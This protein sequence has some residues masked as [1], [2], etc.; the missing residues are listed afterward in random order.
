MIQLSLSS[1]EG[2]EDELIDLTTEKT[3]PSSATVPTYNNESLDRYYY[4]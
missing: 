2:S 3:M 1:E 4:S